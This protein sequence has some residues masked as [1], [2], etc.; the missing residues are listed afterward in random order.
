MDAVYEGFLTGDLQPIETLGVDAKALG[1]ISEPLAKLC[2]L[3]Q[4]AGEPGH[5]AVATTS[6]AAAAIRTAT[7][8]K[9][10]ACGAE[11]RNS[12]ATCLI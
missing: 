3:F 11:A 2:Q 6:S 12:A 4:S 10:S 1:C 9:S 8:V 5:A 7:Q